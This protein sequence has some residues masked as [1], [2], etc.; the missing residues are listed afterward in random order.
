MRGEV[1]IVGRHGSRG[2]RTPAPGLPR[3]R[4]CPHAP[5]SAAGLQRRVSWSPRRRIAYKR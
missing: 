2:R 1:D 4:R 3:A 5:S